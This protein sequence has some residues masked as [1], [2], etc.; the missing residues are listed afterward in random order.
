MKVGCIFNS[1]KRNCLTECFF[2]IK[3]FFKINKQNSELS[4]ILIF[5]AERTTILIVFIEVKNTSINSDNSIFKSTVG[6][7]YWI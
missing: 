5:K 2:K 6:F 1:V 3:Y 7:N 4:T